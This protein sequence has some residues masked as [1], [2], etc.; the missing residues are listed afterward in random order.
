MS[1]DELVRLK[2]YL[3]RHGY[4]D[5]KVMAITIANRY[6]SSAVQTKM[7]GG[8]TG[9]FNLQTSVPDYRKK[10]RNST[11]FRPRKC[12]PVQVRSGTVSGQGRGAG[13]LHQAGI[14]R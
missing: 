7:K 10:L 11:L 8:S 4:D 9:V 1:D 3:E 12:Q 6:I 14:P 5:I 2:S 13:F